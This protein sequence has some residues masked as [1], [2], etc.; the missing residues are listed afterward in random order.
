MSTSAR[1][2]LADADAF[3]VAVARLCDPEGAGRQKYLIVGGSA[4]GRG[5]VTS[6]S[7][8]TRAFGVRSGMPTAQALRLCPQA[9][10]VGVPRRAC[11]EKSREIREVLQRFTPSVEAASVDEFYLDMTG[12]GAWDSVSGGDTLHRFGPM[13]VPLSFRPDTP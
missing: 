11:S 2:L 5:V 7:Y 1:I 3:F 13:G 4:S 6:A 10:P 9:V 8:E 12:N